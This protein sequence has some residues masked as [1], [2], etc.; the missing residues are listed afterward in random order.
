[1]CVM[2]EQNIVKIYIVAASLMQSVSSFTYHVIGRK[3]E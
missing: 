1:M 3:A 2:Y